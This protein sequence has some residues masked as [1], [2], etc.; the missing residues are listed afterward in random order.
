[1]TLRRT[2]PLAIAF[3]L[4]AAALIATVFATRH[5]VGE[6]FSVVSD[7]QALTDEQAV[8][9]DLAD[10]DG[11]PTSSQLA[12]V[13]K[14]H[15]DEGVRYI[16]LV[17]NRAAIIAEAGTAK[18]AFGPRS[19]PT[20]TERPRNRNLEV[21]HVGGRLRIETPLNYR[22][23]GGGGA[24]WL[25]IEVEPSD[26]R[27]LRTA[28]DRTMLI[29]ALS[30]LAMLGV[31]IALVRRELRRQKEASERERRERLASLGEMSAVLAHEIK[32]PLASLKGNAQLLASAL[33]EGQKPKQKAQRVV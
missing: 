13:L 28:S 2:P 5:T 15:D 31:A 3:A 22:R 1:M 12:A 4:M 18:G 19:R 27:E 7:G 24:R 8:R 29:A 30:A 25:V 32:N 14:D 6:A 26:A 10:L 20:R 11:M 9:A 33:P 17:D 21:Q 23:F 16:A